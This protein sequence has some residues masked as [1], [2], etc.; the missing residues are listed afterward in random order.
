MRAWYKGICQYCGADGA[1]H[2]DHI[3]PLA[4][5]GADDLSN[6]TLACAACNLRKATVPLDPM[7]LAIAHARARDNAERIRPLRQKPPRQVK[8]A[9]QLT[10]VDPFGPMARR[11]LVRLYGEEEAQRRMDLARSIGESK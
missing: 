3:T 5:G 9:R 2:V 10:A 1:N 11:R 8:A 7:F 4:M 6:V